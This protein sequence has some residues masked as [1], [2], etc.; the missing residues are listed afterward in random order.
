MNLA[1]TFASSVL[2]ETLLKKLPTRLKRLQELTHHKGFISTRYENLE[3]DG[4]NP[5]FLDVVL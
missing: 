1:M 3:T 2:E 5:G 4:A